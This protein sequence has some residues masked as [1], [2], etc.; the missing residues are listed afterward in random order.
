M[1]TGWDQSL[2]VWHAYHP[3]KKHQQNMPLS[4]KDV[5]EPQDPASHSEEEETEDESENETS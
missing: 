3:S 4:S 5:E 1:S 2:R